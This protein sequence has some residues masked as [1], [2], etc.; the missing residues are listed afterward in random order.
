MLAHNFEWIW[1][2]ISLFKYLYFE[3]WL[4]SDRVMR[5]L[6]RASGCESSPD[7]NLAIDACMFKQ[8]LFYNFHCFCCFIVRSR[9]ATSFQ[10]AEKNKNK[11]K[12]ERDASNREFVYR[13]F[14]LVG[15]W[16][17]K[18][19]RKTK[20]I[21]F[22]ETRNNKT[23]IMLIR[24]RNVALETRGLCG[25]VKSIC[26]DTKHSPSRPLCLGND[27]VKHR[28]NE[29]AKEKKEKGWE[30]IKGSEWRKHN[31]TADDDGCS[32]NIRRSSKS[33]RELR[34]RENIFS[35]DCRFISQ[36]G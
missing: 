27:Y 28:T 29:R 11:R 23:K 31:T 21:F 18:Q 14:E 20:I 34:R 16:R 36:R 24:V 4:S 3:F 13:F 12:R 25:W 2:K 8:H 9:L 33:T 17:T 35:I 10:V 30:G 32:F 26:V 19:K 5:Q 6:P 7:Y 1:M 22:E 15:L